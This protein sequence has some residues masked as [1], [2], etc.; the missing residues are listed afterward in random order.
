MEKSVEKVN[1][2]TRDFHSSENTLGQF[3]KINTFLSQARIPRLSE[4]ALDKLGMLGF[5]KDLLK[6]FPRFQSLYATFSIR[7]LL[8]NLMIIV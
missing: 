3:S 4:N 5:T 6:I 1:F 7:I 2:A 8:L